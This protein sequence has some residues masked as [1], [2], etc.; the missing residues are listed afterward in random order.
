MAYRK[1]SSYFTDEAVIAE[2]REE[3]KA[4]TREEITN[5][6]IDLQCAIAKAILY[7]ESLNSKGDPIAP[8]VAH[9][10]DEVQY[11]SIRIAAERDVFENHIRKPDK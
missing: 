9:T 3:L 5:F 11:E 10:I 1:L 2:A 6:Y 7:A 8:I 4:C